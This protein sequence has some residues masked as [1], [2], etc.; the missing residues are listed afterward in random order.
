MNSSTFSSIDAEPNAVIPTITL[1][2]AKTTVD[3]PFWYANAKPGNSWEAAAGL[4]STSDDMAKWLAYLIRTA[5]NKPKPDDPKIISS[6]I[7]NEIIRPRIVSDLQLW[8]C[9]VKRGVSAYPEF[10]TPLYALGVERH[11]LQ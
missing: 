7:L 2:D 5:Q 8:F 6:E 11:Q 4:F 10:S 3:L 9:N 1:D